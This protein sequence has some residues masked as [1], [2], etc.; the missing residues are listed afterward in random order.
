VRR[1]GARVRIAAHLVEATSHTTLWSEHYDRGLDDTFAVQDEIA[2]AIAD[3]LQATFTSFSTSCID[4]AAYDLYLRASIK[5]YA[6]AELNASVGLLEAAVQRAPNFAEA[7]GRL[8]YVR[9]WAR[10]YQPFAERAAS[11]ALVAR[12]AERA[13]ALDPQNVDA[14]TA[15]YFNFPPYGSFIASD[16]A[17][18]RVRRAPGRGEGQIYIGWHARTV[19]RTRECAELAEEVYSSDPLNP[20]CV[21]GTSLARIAHGQEAEAIPLLQDLMA[22]SPEMSFPVASLL[23]AFALLNDWPAVD[24]LLATAANQPTREFED[25]L[26]FVRAKRNPTAENIGATRD[27]LEAHVAKA[28]SVDVKRFVYAAHLGLVDDVYRVVEGARLGPRG[29]ADDMIGPDAY[30]TGM[31]FWKGM[32]EIRNDPRFVPLCARLG[33]VEFWLATQKWPDCVDEVPY[34]F[35]A[36]CE[37]ARSIS[38]EAFEF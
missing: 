11:A 20:M 3:A 1:A 34:D 14:L 21:M 4:P 29:A 7:W 22:R 6:P 10:L 5:S 23:N 17:M 28:G 32:P 35:K 31:L 13:L 24:R 30:R 9:T 12:E 27:A 2:E 33:L 25:G 26:M 37:E 8:A 36:A 38:K 19:G 15:Q 16:A 18:E